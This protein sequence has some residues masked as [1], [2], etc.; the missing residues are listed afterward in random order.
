MSDPEQLKCFGLTK[1][2]WE[3]ILQ[4]LSLT[5]QIPSGHDP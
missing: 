1:E 4:H 3:L 5:L 2:L